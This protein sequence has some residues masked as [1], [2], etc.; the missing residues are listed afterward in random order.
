MENNKYDFHSSGKHFVPP[1]PVRRREK[2]VPAEKIPENPAPSEEACNPNPVEAEKP[3]PEEIPPVAAESQSPDPATSQPLR[4]EKYL[5]MFLS[6]Q[7]EIAELK[8]T[9]AA[10]D[11]LK[12]ELAE[13]DN[14]LATKTAEAQKF[15]DALT[16][17]IADFDNYR[18]RT[19]E[20]TPKNILY[21]KSSLAKD[22]LPVVDNFKLALDSIKKT[23]PDAGTLIEGVEMIEK[24][25][26]AALAKHEIVEINP[27]GE[28]FNPQ[29][30][31]AI[32]VLPSAEVEEDHIMFVQRTGFKLGS[33]LLRPA[34]VVVAKKPE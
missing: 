16:R 25:V 34:S 7:K 23:N 11:A 27:V 14:L 3:I 10:T 9:L 28:L 29:E 18:R 1:P 4:P 8:K 31:D 19:A 20:E 24:Q 6:A 32:S 17:S 15:K 33:Q 5:D 22:I 30:H 26:L 21:G 12:A 2:S 13:K